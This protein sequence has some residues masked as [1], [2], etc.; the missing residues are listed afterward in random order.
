MLLTSVPLFYCFACADYS[1]LVAAGQW[2]H[3]FPEGGI[4][5]NRSLGG[6][7][8]TVNS[9]GPFEETAHTV[10]TATTTGKARVNANTNAG[11]GMAGSSINTVTTTT[12][13]TTSSSRSSIS[14]SGDM[15]AEVEMESCRGKLRWGI[16]KMIAHA[17][18]RPRVIPFFF[19][20]TENAYPQ[21]ADASKT[22]TNKLP[23][24]NHDVSIR[25]G[26]EI[27]FDDLIAEHEQ[28]HGPLWKYTSSLQQDKEVL[29]REKKANTKRREL[30]RRRELVAQDG[31]EVEQGGEGEGEE[32]EVD[33]DAVPQ[34]RVENPAAAA[35]TAVEGGLDAVEEIEPYNFHEHWDS[36][37]EDLVL[38]A[39]IACRIEGALE[40]LNAAANGP[41]R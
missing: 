40:K 8:V 38:Y 21:S 31:Q 11:A 33:R 28:L 16:G 30:E 23:R 15:S 2:C 17:P 27:F 13:T 32:E 24:I 39:K 29:A 36:R 5:Q 25:V 34:K 1:R 19:M 18:V 12:T 10:H 4:W 22:V 20:G 35:S 3:V 7:G 14:S 26:A 9:G 37:P 41:V 6:R